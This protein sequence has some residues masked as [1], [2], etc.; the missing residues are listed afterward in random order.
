MMRLA[1]AIID[2]DQPLVVSE[3]ILAESAYVLAAIY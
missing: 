1:A 3:L 2:S